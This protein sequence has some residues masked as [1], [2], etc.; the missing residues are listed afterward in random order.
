MSDVNAHAD[1]MIE[2]NFM[3]CSDEQKNIVRELVNKNEEYLDRICAAYVENEILTSDIIPWNIDLMKVIEDLLGIYVKNTDC[4]E[5]VVIKEF[6]NR[7]RISTGFNLFVYL[8]SGYCSK[9]D[10]ILIKR[11]VEVVPDVIIQ[12][13]ARVVI[14]MCRNANI[15]I[16]N[17]FRENY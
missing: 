11:T 4:T 12:D 9:K 5:A 13:A 15:N 10:G 16:E 7:L 2:N 8:S 17:Y 1:Y 6:I 14:V 3:D